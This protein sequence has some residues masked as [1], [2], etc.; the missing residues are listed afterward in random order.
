M[1][2]ATPS[3]ATT[4][5][6]R[7]RATRAAIVDALNTVD[8]LTGYHTTPDQPVAGAAWPRWTETTYNG[9]LCTL[10]RSSYDVL[11]TLPADY[12]ADT[13]DQG[14]GYRDVV[15][16]ALLTVGTVASAEPRTL[17]F[18]DTAMPGLLLRLVVT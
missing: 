9:P 12:V 15:A 5:A 17:T 3:P 16:Y 8:G 11:I 14:D 18:G 13:V 10:A 7:P 4:A 6:D 1:S 2:L